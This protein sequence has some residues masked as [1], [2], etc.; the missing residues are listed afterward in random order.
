MSDTVL[1][2]IF[3]GALVAVIVLARVLK[4][5]NPEGYRRRFVNG[6]PVFN[7][8]VRDA[9]SHDEAFPFA[10]TLYLGDGGSS[11]HSHHHA[12]VD[13]AHTSDAG[14][15]CSDGGGGSSH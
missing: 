10:S 4:S 8:P 12:S 13:C 7:T 5:R 2:L 3:G 6:T 15:A 9:P 11:S 14:G 1:A